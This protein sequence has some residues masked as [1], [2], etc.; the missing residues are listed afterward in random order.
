MAVKALPTVPSHAPGHGVAQILNTAIIG[1]KADQL[2]AGDF[3]GDTTSQLF[4]APAQCFV[5]DVILNISEAFSAST[6]MTIGDGDDADRFFDTTSAAPT[7]AGF[8]SM[9]QDAN[10]GSGG[11]VYA[12]QDTIDLVL[13]GA[14]PTA[15]TLDVYLFYTLNASTYLNV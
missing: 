3:A 1:V 11:H 7:V 9:K 6:T 5:F 14:T 15:G 13:S 8:K 10:P 2:D 4:T 12:A